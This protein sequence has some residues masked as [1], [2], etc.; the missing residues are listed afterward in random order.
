MTLQLARIEEVIENTE[1]VFHQEI[2]T[3]ARDK[4]N[5]LYEGELDLNKKF[6]QYVLNYKA[7]YEGRNTRKNQI[8][9][10]SVSKK[11]RLRK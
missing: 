11:D 4:Y 8:I 3:A 1:G 9:D 5:K 7:A 10:G 2:V 6:N